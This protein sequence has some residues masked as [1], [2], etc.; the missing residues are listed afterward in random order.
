MKNSS[1]SLSIFTLIISFLTSCIYANTLSQPHSQIDELQVLMK[2]REEVK[3]GFHDGD[4]IVVRVRGELKPLK[5]TLRF[6]DAS[7]IQLMGSSNS[8]PINVKDIRVIRRAEDHRSWNDEIIEYLLLF[9]AQGT[10]VQGIQ[11]LFPLLYIPQL[12]WIPVGFLGFWFVLNQ[13]RRVFKGIRLGKRRRI[14][15][16]SSER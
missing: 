1:I 3:Y 15:L 11:I 8:S 13:I 6:H 7:H 9:G 2:K 12:W 16:S 5:G 4:E 14:R 10:V